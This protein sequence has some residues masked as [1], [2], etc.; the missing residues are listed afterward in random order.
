MLA[1]AFEV[2]QVSEARPGAPI[3]VQEWSSGPRPPAHL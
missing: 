2:S 1:E 3:I